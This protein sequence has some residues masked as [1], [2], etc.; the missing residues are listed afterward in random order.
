MKKNYILSA[1]FAISALFTVSC[2]KEYLEVAPESSESP[3]TIFA[4]TDIEAT[5]QWGGLPVGNAAVKRHIP[6]VVHE[7]NSVLG[8][9][10]K[11]LAKKAA[12]VCLTYE[13]AASAVK[14][15]SKVIL[16]GCPVRSSVF[17]MTRDEGRAQLDIPDDARMLLVTGGSLGAKHLNEALCAMKERLL[18]YEDLIII[19]VT[20]PKNFDDT[21]A[22]LALTDEE[23]KR[24]RVVEIVEKAK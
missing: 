16:T 2:S 24:W 19:H 20:G 3:A 15:A 1:C 21:K 23:A 9:A 8:M 22:R 13:H 4:T 5:T 14:D 12:A 11:H 6:L 17:S 7:Q 18:G 10:N